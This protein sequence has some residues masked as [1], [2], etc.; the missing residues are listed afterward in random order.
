[1][2]AAHNYR[3][4][5]DAAWHLAEAWSGDGLLGI[6]GGEA[7]ADLDHALKHLATR[8][9]VKAL[10]GGMEETILRIRG[11]RAAFAG[12]TLLVRAYLCGWLAG[13]ADSE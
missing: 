6:D 7:V 5:E 12:A 2:E 1:M 10:I 11:E 4:L 13:S 8:E 3:I 9:Q